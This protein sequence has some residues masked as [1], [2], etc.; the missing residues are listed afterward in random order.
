VAG[1]RDQKIEVTRA[2]LDAKQWKG[3]ARRRGWLN[4]LLAVA[5]PRRGRWPGRYVLAMRATL[6][7]LAVL[8][9]ACARQPAVQA[10]TLAE[11]RL[12]L[13]W[14]VPLRPAKCQPRVAL[15]MH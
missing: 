13:A 6:L 11:S 1:L 10:T 8:L 12:Y 14:P 9:S 5:G 15:P 2:R 3:K 4:W 7:L